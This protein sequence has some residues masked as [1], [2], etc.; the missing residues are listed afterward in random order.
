MSAPREMS[1]GLATE[2]LRGPVMAHV[3]SPDSG[4]RDVR[5][6]DYAFDASLLFALGVFRDLQLSLVLPTRLYQSGAGAGGVTSQSAAPVEQSAL[7]DPRFGVAYSLDDAL[8]K[9]GL[10]L[11]LAFDASLPLGDKSAFAGER[12]VVAMPSVTFGWQITRFALRASLAARL[13]SAVDF[14]D[15]HLGNE[16]YFALGAGVDV[17]APG[18]LFLSLEGFALPPLTSSRSAYANAALTSVSLFP[19]EWLF[20]VHSSLRCDSEWSLAAS[21]GTGLP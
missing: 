11:R 18:L 16:G 9:A 15:V 14:G 1:L 4:G 2:L 21:I 3:S 10:G 7:R 5:F 6:V 13:R 17:L 8:S 20:G 12:S 19:A